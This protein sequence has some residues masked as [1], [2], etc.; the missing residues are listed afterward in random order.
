VK[1]TAGPCRAAVGHAHS[2]ERSNSEAFRWTQETGYELL[3]SIPATVNSRAFDVS[4]DGS[5]ILGTTGGNSCCGNGDVFL[6]SEA[7]GP[8][9]LGF[10]VLG[11]PQ[12]IEDDLSVIARSSGGVVRWDAANGVQPLGFDASFVR[13]SDD[14][15]TM[16][17]VDG[18]EPFVWTSAAGRRSLDQYLTEHGLDTTGWSALEATMISRDGR[19]LAGEGTN[20][21]GGRE[22]WYAVVPEPSTSA[23]VLLGLSFLGARSH[24]CSKVTGAK[25]L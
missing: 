23:L 7:G 8:E 5:I 14:G 1:A 11:R 20:P 12:L 15:D 18:L 21:S 2:N 16:I 17:G 6:W 9:W 10:S 22:N 3:H 4:F 24:R 13:A 25:S 19:V